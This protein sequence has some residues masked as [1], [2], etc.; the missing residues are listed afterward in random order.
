MAGMERHIMRANAGS[1]T[2]ASLVPTLA[3]GLQGVSVPQV[4]QYVDAYYQ[5]NPGQTGRAGVDV[6]YRDMAAPNAA[7]LR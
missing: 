7:R 2:R 6:I 1:G 5:A 3:A 4:I